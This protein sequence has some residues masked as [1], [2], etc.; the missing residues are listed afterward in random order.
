M[1]TIATELDA[2]LQQLAPDAAMHIERLIHQAL[3]ESGLPRAADQWPP[4]YFAQTAG[5]FAG[6]LIERPPQGG[7]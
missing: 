7:F 1:S 2:R 6:E 3:A 5:A 4:G